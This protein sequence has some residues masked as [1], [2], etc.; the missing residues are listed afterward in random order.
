MKQGTHKAFG[1]RINAWATG[2]LVALVVLLQPSRAA[3]I[4]LMSTDYPPYFASSLPDGGPLTE[5]VTAAFTEAG[6][7]ANIQFVPWNRAME[8]A[9]AGKVDGLHGG[10]HSRA[11][12]AWFVFSDPLPGNELVFYKRR[13]SQPDRFTSYE[14]LKAF[15]IGIV[16]AYRNP[17][18]FEAAGLDTDAADSDQTNLRKLANGRID[19]ILIDRAVAGYLLSTEFAEYKDRL[20]ALE[21]AVETLDLHVLISRKVDSH[22][23][24]VDDFNRGLKRVA[25][26]GRVSEIL[27]KHGLSSMTER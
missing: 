17:A 11:R 3:E 14:N 23:D 13:G 24:L 8:Y 25:S 15:T 26:Q 19:L 12:E 10:W 4:E 18:A 9:K 6:H 2:I 20:E 21:P 7:H 1:V 27:R 22:R 16:K 5:I